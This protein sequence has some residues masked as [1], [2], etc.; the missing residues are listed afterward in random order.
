M[1]AIAISAKAVKSVAKLAGKGSRYAGSRRTL[2]HVFVSCDGQALRI[3]ATDSYTLGR[4][5]FELAATDDRAEFAALF[6][7]ASLSSLKA[8]DRCRIEIS[9]D[10]RAAI[11]TAANLRIPAADADAEGLKWPAGTS[12]LLF[13]EKLPEPSAVVAVDPKKLA[14]ATAPAAVLDGDSRHA[15][16][17]AIRCAADNAAM[18]IRAEGSAAAYDAVLMP[19]RMSTVSIVPAAWL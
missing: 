2:T 3:E 12:R 19:V 9:E 18:H 13:P 1:K 7:A 6:P 5:T 11:V 14:A 8:S 17:V 4:F 16:P 10:G 15:A